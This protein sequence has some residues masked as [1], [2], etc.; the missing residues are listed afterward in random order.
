[1]KRNTPKEQ[2][3]QCYLRYVSKISVVFK[4]EYTAWSEPHP[5]GSAPK[6]LSAQHPRDNECIC[7]RRRRTLV[8][9]QFVLQTKNPLTKP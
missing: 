2:K 6:Y 5:A 1:M 3:D 9:L 4:A 8:E 7:M